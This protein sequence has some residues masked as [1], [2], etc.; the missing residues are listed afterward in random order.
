MNQDEINTM[1]SHISSV[2]RTM[3]GPSPAAQSFLRELK[4]NSD[5]VRSYEQPHLLVKKRR[6]P[7]FLLPRLLIHSLSFMHTLGTSIK[8][9]PTSR[10]VRKSRMRLYWSREQWPGWPTGTT[11]FALVQA[12]LFPLGWRTHLWPM[13]SKW[14]ETGF[15]VPDLTLYTGINK[16]YRS[17]PGERWR[18][19]VRDWRHR[20]LPVSSM[21]LDR[22]IPKIQVSRNL[23]FY[24]DWQMFFIFHQWSGQTL[25]NK[26]RTMWRMGQ[27]KSDK[28]REEVLLTCSPKVLYIMLS[29]YRARS[30]TG[31]G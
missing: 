10:F 5:L 15:K 14:S 22:S 30:Q 12:W 28:S 16:G 29:C 24:T 11:A 9:D 17:G 27:C 23:I 6:A 26:K 31:F 19:A 21:S 20:T 13:Y 1:V 8:C 7:S 3:L 2:W 25:T 18:T 4:S